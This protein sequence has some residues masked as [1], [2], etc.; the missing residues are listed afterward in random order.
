MNVPSHNQ[1]RAAAAAVK[2][3]PAWLP[4]PDFPKRHQGS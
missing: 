4:E 3:L 1:L 2:D